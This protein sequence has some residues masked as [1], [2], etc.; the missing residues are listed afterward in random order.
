MFAACLNFP[1]HRIEEERSLTGLRE[2]FPPWLPWFC[3]L[4]ALVL[5]TC[6]PWPTV[7]ITDECRRMLSTLADTC[8]ARSPLFH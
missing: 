6:R 7:D 1:F 2:A 4:F 3:F 5:Q 8:L